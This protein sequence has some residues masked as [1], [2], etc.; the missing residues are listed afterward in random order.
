MKSDDAA[1]QGKLTRRSLLKKS[2]G[3]ALGAAAASLTG[4]LAARAQVSGLT[5]EGAVPPLR[6]PL[7]ALD[8]LDRKQ[9]IHNMDIVS[10][11]PGGSIAGGEPLMAMW[12][13]GKQR[14]L[15]AFGGFIDVSDAK[16]PAV[17]IKG[18]RGLGFNATVFHAKTKKWISMCTAAAPLTSATPE[19]PHGAYD[20]PLRD[21]SINF[22]GL[23][24]IRT[25]D[26]TDPLKPNLLQEF[27]TGKT[28]NG[29]HHNFYDGG[30][31]A[32][33]DCGWDDQLRMENHQ[34]PTS[35]AIMIVDMS[36]PAS[37]KEVS[38]WW[39]PGQ[40]FGEEAEYKKYIFADD[41][42]S[43]T[44]NHGALSV[45]KRVENGG[46]VGYGGFG[47]F[48]MYAMDL[49]DI[50]NPKP[51]GHVQYEFNP[52]GDIP[53]HTCYP[54]IPDPAHPRLSN[55]VVATHEILEADCRSPYHTPYVVDVKDPRNP[56]I[57]GF[58]PRPA[59]PPDAPYTDFCFARGRFGSHNTQCWLAPGASKS[60][61]MVMS[62]FNAGVRV[63]DISNPTEPKEIA[64][65][66]P[67][68]DGDIEKYETW[69]R[70]T[71]ED[72]FVEWDRNLIW[73]GTHEGSYCLSCPALG[74][75]VTEPTKVSRWTV[76]PCNAGWDAQTAATF[77][78]GRSTS[79][80]G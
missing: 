62:Y 69:W 65:F 30:Q 74:K 55:L 59:A 3:A 36:D 67:P 71:T 28:G 73:I 26:V 79:Q 53:F 6:M 57:I 72:V 77:Y 45:P 37:V 24:G 61:I 44:G 20:K 43:W 60:H 51:Y 29:T 31:Y 58:F 12:A 11:L 2:A 48:G 13:K 21:R 17:A 76:P 14:M 38:K 22:T 70:G 46:T 18:V 16:K 47:A 10:H 19:F 40:R 41:H 54:V 39:V 68:R 50:K 80:M 1:K 52:L 25:F 66:V 7:G 64:W 42:A 9:Y 15:P 34:R 23:R 5:P 33:L 32:Y 78:F 49:S 35:N 56:K 4:A 75:P 63:F 8:F 27:S